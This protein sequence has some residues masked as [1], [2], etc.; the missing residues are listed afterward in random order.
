M[1]R[2]GETTI[3]AGLAQARAFTYQPKDRL[4]CPNLPQ[5][6]A[7]AASRRGLLEDQSRG[8]L[9]QLIEPRRTS[10]HETVI[11]IL[12]DRAANVVLRWR[13]RHGGV[14]EEK[15]AQKVDGGVGSMTVS[16]PEQRRV[17]LTRNSL[18]VRVQGDEVRTCPV[19]V[20]RCTSLTESAWSWPHAERVGAKRWFLSSDGKEIKIE[21]ALDHLLTL[22]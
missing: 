20:G 14:D 5:A 12:P 7:T 1:S 8:T 9:R 15:L 3:A 13:R 17:S 22:F 10:S 4:N 16:S 11:P 21:R 6:G 2:R 19:Q 18:P